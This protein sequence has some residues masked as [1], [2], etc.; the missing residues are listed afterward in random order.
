MVQEGK[1]QLQREKEQFLTEW[2]TVKEVVSKSCHS[3]S[4]LA[5]KEHESVEVVLSTP[6]EV[7]D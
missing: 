6:Q 1:V 7:R 2:T 4:G 5:Q 3:V